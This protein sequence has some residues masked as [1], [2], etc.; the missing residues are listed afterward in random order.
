MRSDRRLPWLA[1]AL[2]VPAQSLSALFMLFWMPGAAGKAIAVGLRVYMLAFPIVWTERVERRRPSLAPPRRRDLVVGLAAGLIIF[3]VM[4]AA[5]VL[6]ADRIDLG[7]LRERAEA[8]GFAR[9]GPFAAT[10]A[11]IAIVNALLEEY[12]WRWFVY[13]QVE[14]IVP[15]S[16][17]ERRR[18]ASAVAIA[19]GLFTIHHVILLAGWVGPGVNALA[20]SGV[21]LGAL[22]WSA[23]YARERSLWPCYVSHAVADLAILVMGYDLLFRS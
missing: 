17:G 13:R 19:A 5:Y 7:P 15:A 1:L 20:S 10:F 4:L 9:L 21:F 3:A 12:V 22:I 16:I 2:L 8:T 11:Y 18:R 14:A 6:V 23:L